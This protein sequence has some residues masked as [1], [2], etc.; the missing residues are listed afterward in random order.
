MLAGL[1]SH[2]NVPPHDAGCLGSSCWKV[3]Q[4]MP[5]MLAC[6]GLV[7]ERSSALELMT[8]GEAAFGVLRLVFFRFWDCGL[9]S[10]FC[11]VRV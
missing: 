2:G 9:G 11:F 5:V 3:R 6:C 7:P 8:E 10:R 1:G 4:L